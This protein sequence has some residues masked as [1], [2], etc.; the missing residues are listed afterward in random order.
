MSEDRQARIEALFRSYRESLP[1]L[2]SEI[3]SM[4]LKLK[5]QW[6]TDIATEFNRKVHGLAGSAAT[7]ALQEIGDVARE[8][9]HSFKPLLDGSTDNQAKTSVEQLISTLAK[10]IQET[11]N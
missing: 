11:I 3:D 8:L 1:E 9:E 4:W 10:S 6:D 5:Q 7:F 2:M